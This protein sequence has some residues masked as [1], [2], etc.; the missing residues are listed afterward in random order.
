MRA[1]IAYINYTKKSRIFHILNF[2]FFC[3]V[4][5]VLKSG[6]FVGNYKTQI[7]FTQYYCSCCLE[8]LRNL[9]NM[10]M[11][12][13]MCTRCMMIFPYC[14]LYNVQIEHVSQTSLFPRIRAEKNGSVLNGRKVACMLTLVYIHVV[15]LLCI[16][17]YDLQFRLHNVTVFPQIYWRK[18]LERRVFSVACS[19]RV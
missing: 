8:Y 19:H 2:F 14:V 5:I 6:D 10:C 1:R 4:Y 11:H 17:V 18:S 7:T 3:V 13:C 12:M 15:C 9:P 16:H